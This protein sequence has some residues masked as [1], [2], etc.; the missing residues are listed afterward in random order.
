MSVSLPSPPWSVSLPPAPSS[1][2]LPTAPVSVLTPELPM[3]MLASALPV[4]SAA[5]V[6]VSVRFS[7]V[8]RTARLRVIVET[9]LSVPAVS[10]TSTV[11]DPS[12]RCRCRC[13]R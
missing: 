1:V 11:Y 13:R 7:I 9:I 3:M 2:S 12:C 8:G 4:P 10:T 6:P 5:A